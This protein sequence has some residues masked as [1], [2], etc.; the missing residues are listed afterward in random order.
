MQYYTIRG[1]GLTCASVK[2]EVLPCQ[3]DTCISTTYEPLLRWGVVAVKSKGPQYKMVNTYDQRKV[4][5]IC[6]G[7][8][9]AKTA[10]RTS[11]HLSLWLLG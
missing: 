6:T 1:V 5:D 8:P 10:P 7:V 11:R 2:A 3:F 4:T 9:S